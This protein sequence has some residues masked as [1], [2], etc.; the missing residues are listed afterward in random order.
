M[1]DSVCGCGCNSGIEASIKAGGGIS[2]VT[3][4][5]NY[6]EPLFQL[7]DSLFYIMTILS[8]S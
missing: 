7:T 4:V 3:Y 1:D 8:W 5:V 2:C 6:G